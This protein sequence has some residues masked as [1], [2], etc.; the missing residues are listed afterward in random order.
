MSRDRDPLRGPGL[1]VWEV[2]ALLQAVGDALNTRFAAV[3]VRGEI[4]GFSRA[5]SGHCY[6]TLK[7]QDGSAALRC[8]MFRRAA[9]LLE[10]APRDGM[11]VEVRGR[12]AVYEARGELQLIV[13]ALRPAGAGALMEQFLRLKA[14]LQA[15]GLFDAARKRP[16]NPYPRRIGIV[17]SLGAAALHDVVTALA[18]RA[19]QVE[20]IVYP[21]P[22]QGAG[23]AA[24][25]TA[26]VLQASARAE[27]DTL[28]LCR[29]GGSVEDLWA[30]ND[31]Q[32]VHVLAAAP[33]PVISGIG[34]ETDFTLCDFVADLRAPTPTAAAELAAT[35]RED[36]L[37]ALTHAERRLSLRLHASLDRQAQALDRLTLRLHKPSEL[38]RREQQ[39]LQGLA[40]RL[41]LAAPQGVA[42]QARQLM[43]LAQR[44]LVAQRH[45]RASATQGLTAV[46]ARLQAL[47]PSRVLARG[48]AWV[49]DD[50]HPA[51]TSVDQVQP[52]RQVTI[53][54]ADG[55]V[56][57]VVQEVLRDGRPG[58][59]PQR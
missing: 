36:C 21:S 33:M 40:Q 2:P 9:V 57:S 3:A 17:S 12:V 34:H 26:A 1:M 56:Q 28:L 25:L 10:V 6:F 4:S 20:L 30:F 11:V 49:S 27:V 41:G 29:G 37:A 31:E 5:A 39:R 38:L 52:G 58:P 14:R 44:L 23:A 55:R 46:A 24:Q 51:I 53:T 8:A 47:D 32:L 19:P 43:H 13:E 50:G 7:A 15:Q 45:Q 48:Y 35:P 59:L 22:V 18:R 42:R 16:V 54:L